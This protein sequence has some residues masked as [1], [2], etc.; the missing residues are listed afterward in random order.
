MTID[1]IEKVTPAGVTP[2]GK[3]VVLNGFPGTGKL[4]ILN[5]LKSRLAGQDNIVID[6]HFI[7]DPVQKIYPDRGLNHYYLRQ[8]LRQVIFKEIRKLVDRGCVVLMTACL[9]N[10]EGDRKV[11]DEHLVIVRGTDIS[12]FWINVGCDQHTLEERLTR[13][14]RVQGSKAKLTNVDVLRGMTKHS[15]IIIPS[16]TRHRL[17]DISLVTASLDVGGTIEE[18][19]N[20]VYNVVEGKHSK[21]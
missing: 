4:T 15:R 20:K 10:N 19:V 7:I 12:M 21:L 14:E 6:N 2:R 1:K 5:N 11:L 16:G 18:A 3:V 17:E 9:G 13:P 8:Q